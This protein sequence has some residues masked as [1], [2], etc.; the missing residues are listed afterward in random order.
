MVKMRKSF[1]AVVCIG[2]IAFSI[3]SIPSL[4]LESTK[5]QRSTAKIFSHILEEER[6]MYISLPDGYAASE[7]MY[8]ILYVL[9]AEGETLFPKCVSTVKDLNA[10][11]IIPEM[12][13][14]G[15]WNTNRNRD[16]IPESVSHRPGSGGSEHFLR[17]I[18]NEL[19]PYIRQNYCASD[20]SLL[21][22]MSNSALFAVYA[23]LEKPET[24]NGIIASSPM[25][26]HCPEYMQKKT[27]T[28]IRKNLAGRLFLYMIYG[29]EDSRRVTE[30]VPD[31]QKY[32]DSY[33][34]KGFTNKLE[35]LEGE[36]HV[37][38]SSLARGL[39]YIFQR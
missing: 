18:Q 33:A 20:Y 16:M 35:I 38:A 2:I 15:I 17:F 7:K 14:V 25:I 3:M 19:I 9:D 5:P 8:P 29:T 1:L 31:F 34:P 21:Y 10:K 39:Q 24:F 32:L 26:G 12:I 36:G 28:F 13:V 4:T 37:P 22:G 11:E 27:E 30:Y 23:L 6:I